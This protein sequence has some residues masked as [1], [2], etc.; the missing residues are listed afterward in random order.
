MRRL[1]GEHDATS[2]LPSVGKLERTSF[3]RAAFRD[4][5][6]LSPR[7]GDARGWG[8]AKAPR[9]G[10]WF[11]FS[12]KSLNAREVNRTRCES[13][14]LG[15]RLLRPPSLPEGEMNGTATAAEAAEA[16]GTLTCSVA[17]AMPDR[18]D[19]RLKS[20][21][22]VK[23]QSVFEHVTCANKHIYFTKNKQ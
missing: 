8:D 17:G 21:D 22:L 15:E 7:L 14:S 4:L 18:S 3:E 16:S 19:L 11:S 13:T 5:G 2:E 6:D 9:P 1:L 12:C 10:R 23:R 20:D